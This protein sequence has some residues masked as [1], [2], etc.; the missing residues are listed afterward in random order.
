MPLR[1]EYRSKVV[2]LSLLTYQQKGWYIC[3]Y[4]RCHQ[5]EI[6]TMKLT[7]TAIK[8]ATPKEKQYKL[9]DGGG[10]YLIIRTSG[11]YWRYNYRFAK[12]QKTLA[13]GV[14]PSVSLKEARSL[15]QE[16][17]KQLTSGID[18]SHQRKLDKITANQQ[19]QDSF[20]AIASEWLSKQKV[21]WSD[22][23]CSNVVSRLENH[24]YPWLGSR[25][26]IEITAPE[27][28]AVLRR[29]ESRGI[30]HTALKTKQ[31]C[32][33]I[34]RYGIVTGRCER[35]PSAD[36][37]GALTTY[38]PTSFSAIT[39]PKEIGGLLRSIA[40]YSGDFVTRQALKLAPLVFVRPTE[41]RHAEWSEID[42]DKALW[43]IPAEKMKMGKEHIVPLS[44][45][46]I[47][48]LKETRE[49]TSNGKYV[50]PSIRSRSRAMS[51]NTLNGALRRMG[52]TKE[53]MTSHGFRAMASTSLNSLGYK[54]DVIE[55]QLA[56]A[57]RNK[58]RAVY[59]RA[60][61]MPERTTMMQQWAD[62]LDGLKAGEVDNVV[63]IKK[64]Q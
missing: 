25:P 30:H 57:E 15:H 60:E 27:L 36:L 1:E 10:L 26:I 62:Y 39:D 2:Y 3:W 33:Q 9:V 59:N 38:K 19:A 52:Y 44:K 61:Y 37:Q 55:R 41:I 64:Y 63:P 18:P 48:I 43:V 17:K 28:L 29:M 4:I 11:K 54:V 46:A 6:P 53:E 45:Q 51:E 5:I 34:F 42:I 14:Y 7:A 56:H 16:A 22:S 21:K 58:V 40:E 12:K 49:L 13:L 35:D 24:I 47:E 23:H 50:F 31:Y 20:Q 8:N 32:G